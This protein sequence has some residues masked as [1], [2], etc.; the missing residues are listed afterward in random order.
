MSEFFKGFLSREIVFA[1]RNAGGFA[2]RLL[3]PARAEAADRRFVGGRLLPGFCAPYPSTRP[4]LWYRR[5]QSRR[6][7]QWKTCPAP[8]NLPLCARDLALI[9]L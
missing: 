5:R 3:F 7:T 6:Q 1:H 8:T 9:I 2:A 4:C